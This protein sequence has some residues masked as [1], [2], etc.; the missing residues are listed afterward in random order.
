M[1]GPGHKPLVPLP[2]ITRQFANYLLSFGV[3]VGL[4]AAPLLGA[5]RIPFFE[6]LV[7]IF[8]E[9][10]Q[11]LLIPVLTFCV[12]FAALAFQFFASETIA[13][14][15]IRKAF[16][17]LLPF[18]VL[19]AVGLLL[20][21]SSYIVRTRTRDVVIGWSRLPSC[22]CG[23]ASDADC[24]D[25]LGPSLGRCWSSQSIFQV[26]ASLFLSYFVAIESFATAVGLLVLQQEKIRQQKKKE[27]KPAQRRRRPRP[28]AP[29]VAEPSPPAEAASEANPAPP[30]EQPTPPASR[31]PSR[32]RSPSAP[33]K[34]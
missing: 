26:R 29:A 27:K 2:A 7:A 18:T 22:L 10:H 31:R 16:I 21:S 5:K 32:R 34:S 11:K 19:S 24:I 3:A 14:R 8:P 25:G 17:I 20:L 1:T 28:A 9:E 23:Y 6:P 30:P 33:P 12:G 4:F 13:R 15:S